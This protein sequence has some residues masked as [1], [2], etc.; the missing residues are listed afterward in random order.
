MDNGMSSM[1]ADAPETWGRPEKPPMRLWEIRHPD[2][3]VGCWVLCAT[4]EDALLR[5]RQDDPCWNRASIPDVN[6]VDM[7]KDGMI[8]FFSFHPLARQ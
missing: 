6:P 5:A 4:P 3:H 1:I 2:N 8:K 7:T